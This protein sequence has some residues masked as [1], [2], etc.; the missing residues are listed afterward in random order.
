MP[1]VGA[2]KNLTPSCAVKT[3]LGD[4]QAVLVIEGSQPVLSTT[5]T[6]KARSKIK[7]FTR[8]LIS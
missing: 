8:Y 1:E 7:R 5:T 3:R 6:L 2:K 4:W